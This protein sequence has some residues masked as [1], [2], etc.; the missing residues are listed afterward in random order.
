MGR[1]SGW[2]REC[3]GGLIMSARSMGPQKWECYPRK[4]TPG[5]IPDPAG[6][7]QSSRIS[8]RTR[9]PFVLLSR[10]RADIYQPGWSM[11]RFLT[12]EATK[13][14]FCLVSLISP[15]EPAYRRCSLNAQ[16]DDN[17][18][19]GRGETS[20]GCECHIELRIRDL[21]GGGGVSRSQG[22]GTM[23]RDRR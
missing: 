19:V 1:T 2:I 11:T 7:L 3:S 16:L 22:L 14:G 13:G 18:L 17:L 20:V 8:L 4:T 6:P 21:N 5:P 9:E 23:G 12:R 10:L 15:K